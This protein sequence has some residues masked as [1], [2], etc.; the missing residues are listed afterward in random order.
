MKI[1]QNFIDLLFQ[2]VKIAAFLIC[3]IIIIFRKKTG[4]EIEVLKAELNRIDELLQNQLHSKKDL[5]EL[6]AEKV[7]LE[8]ILINK[9]VKIE[10]LRSI[11]DSDDLKV[12]RTR[13]KVSIFFF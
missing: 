4:K 5:I 10:H 1:V 8:A 7:E 2:T 6:K 3:S 9:R 13:L 12:V 11:S